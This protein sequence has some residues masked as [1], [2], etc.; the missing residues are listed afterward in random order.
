MNADG[1]DFETNFESKL[2]IKRSEEVLQMLEDE[3]NRKELKINELESSVAHFPSY[4]TKILFKDVKC[5]LNE[6]KNEFSDFRAFVNN[7]V[8]LD[9]KFDAIVSDIEAHN[10]VKAAFKESNCNSVSK[11]VLLNSQIVKDAVS[12]LQVNPTIYNGVSNDDSDYSHSLLQIKAEKHFSDEDSSSNNF[13]VY[14]YEQTF[15]SDSN[16]NHSETI[17]NKLI[18]EVESD[19]NEHTQQQIRPTTANYKINL[20]TEKKATVVCCVCNVTKQYVAPRKRFGKATCD[21][22]FFFFWRF[23][24]KPRQLYCR[25]QGRCKIEGQKRN[26]INRC[27]ACWL[28]T[29]LDKFELDDKTRNFITTKYPPKLQFLPSQN[30]NA[31]LQKA[32]QFVKI[33]AI[34]MQEVKQ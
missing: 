13:K 10:S 28:S 23:T 33:I 7:L 5:S 14:E 19:L 17:H 22:C 27:L 29:C 11:P 18:S 20:K 24:R 21:S 32:V 16:N 31:S 26:S 9:D 4:S 34:Q 30:K 3:I 25:Y 2:W 15:E 8:V 1:V 12:T 6:R